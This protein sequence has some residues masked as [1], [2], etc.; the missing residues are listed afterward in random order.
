[1]GP[2]KILNLIKK[3]KENWIWCQVSRA[4]MSES[5]FVTTDHKPT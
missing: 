3:K 4:N 1:M 5:G 2:T